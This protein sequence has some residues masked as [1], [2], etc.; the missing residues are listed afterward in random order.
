M[1]PISQKTLYATFPR[2]PCQL[3]S[4]FVLPR[5]STG[6]IGRW[7]E[8]TMGSHLTAGS[9]RLLLILIYGPFLHRGSL[10]AK[11]GSTS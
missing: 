6:E 9:H 10:L 11:L 4:D 3:V 8:E 1:E 2:L 5:G 7:E